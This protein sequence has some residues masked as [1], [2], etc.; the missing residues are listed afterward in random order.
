MVQEMT[1]ASLGFGMGSALTEEL[2]TIDPALLQ[3]IVDLEK[4]IEERRKWLLKAATTGEWDGCPVLADSPGSRLATIASK[5]VTDAVELEKAS[6]E[7]QREVLTKER[8]ALRARK[9]LSL[10]RQAVLDLIK[11]MKLKAALASCKTDLG[12]RAI[13]AKA[14]EFA[15]RAVTVTLRT[16]L[17]N[18][19]DALGV[20]HIRTKLN[21]RVEQGKM[22]HKLVLDLPVTKKLDEILSEGE[23]R[24]V[25][26]GSFLAEMRLAG[27]KGG[28]VFD[29]PVSSLDH[30]WRQRVAGRLV[31][32]AAERQVIVFTH[33][34]VF[35]AELL[36]ALDR[37]NANQLVH[38]LDRIS[39]KPGYILPGLPQEHQKYTERL[40][41]HEKAQRK[42]ASNWPAIPGEADREA[43]RREYS[44]LRATIERVV[45]DVVL[46][47]V[48]RRYADW[49]RVGNLGDVVGFCSTEC[50]EIER[51]YQT[52]NGVVD[53]HD[54]SSAKNSS[55]P[56]PAR[57]GKNIADLKA[58]VETII[59]RR[60]AAKNAAAPT[61]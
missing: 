47:G 9:A 5:A 14:K 27:H 18:E 53:A 25:A 59:T 48:V 20:G 32:E 42:L 17:N 1:G 38:H 44:L 49:I 28:I 50:A 61:P 24:A 8:E 21:E 29:D 26:I 31:G 60:K 34:T 43:I 30:H 54:P 2:K 11:R 40:D 4:Q 58:V 56:D 51:L 57:L 45:Q 19:F 6:D 10:R 7:S 35:L 39:D 16:A 36:D 37:S 41:Q 33:D 52:C 46:N 22:K 55:V 3:E 15:S 12:T 23:Q 13:S